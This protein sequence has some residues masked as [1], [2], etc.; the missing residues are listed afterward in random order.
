MYL[1]CQYFLIQVG[2]D[3]WVFTLA[4]FGRPPVLYCWLSWTLNQVRTS[5]DV[6]A[7]NMQYTCRMIQPLNCEAD[8]FL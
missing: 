6:D 4:D 2:G 5:G 8:K 7:G 1:Y 3:S